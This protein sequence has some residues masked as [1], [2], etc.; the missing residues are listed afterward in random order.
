MKFIVHKGC[1]FVQQNQRENAIGFL[2]EYKWKL[3]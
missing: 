3:S 1:N 2:E